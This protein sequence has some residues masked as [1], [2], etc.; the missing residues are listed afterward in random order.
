MTPFKVQRMA[1]MAGVAGLE[2]VT[3]AVTGQR[4]NQL[5]YT[6]AKGNVT[7]ENVWG[8]VKRLVGDN[9]K[10]RA[11]DAKEVGVGDPAEETCCYPNKTNVTTGRLFVNILS[12]DTIY[13]M[14]PDCLKPGNPP[15]R[16]Q[17]SR[18]QLFQNALG[19]RSK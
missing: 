2:P 19:S 4:S 18:R 16:R 3:S 11:A 9:L 10:I 15:R 17:K 5:S 8:R 6:P 12:S 7:I 1:E 13:R 14:N